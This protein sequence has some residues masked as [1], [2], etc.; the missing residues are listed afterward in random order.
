MIN[1]FCDKWQGDVG[2]KQGLGLNL[3]LM[4]LQWQACRSRAKQGL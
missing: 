4:A 3:T 2:G 1:E